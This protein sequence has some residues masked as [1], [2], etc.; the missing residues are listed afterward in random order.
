MSKVRAPYSDLVAGYVTSSNPSDGSFKVKT[1]G[2]EELT[3]K[4]NSA[5]YAEQTRNL[6]DGWTNPPKGYPDMLVPDQYVFA[7]GLWYPESGAQFLEAKHLV[8]PGPGAGEYVFEQPDWWVKQVAQIGDF[9]INGQFGAGEI[10]YKKYRTKLFLDGSRVDESI[11]V[12]Q[13]SSRTVYGFAPTHL[14]AESGNT[15]QETDTISRTVYG[16]AS[17]Y[18]LTGEDRYLEA[19]EKGTKYLQDVMAKREK[20]GIVYWLH[21]VDVVG[22][23]VTEILPSQFGDDY[24]AMPTYEQIYAIA[25][26]TQTY[27]ISGDP[28]ILSDIEKT[29]VLFDEYYKDKGP[30]GGY[31]SHLDP[32]NFSAKSD[33]LGQNKAKKNWNSVGD[34]A[35]AYLINLY[36][37]TGEAKY[38]DFLAYT[39]DTIEAHFP[40]YANSPFVNERFFDDWSHDQGWGWQGNRAVVGHNLK[41][42][43]NLL[44]IQS[45]RPNPKYITF[46]EKIAEIMPKVGMDVQR[47]GWY[48][49]ME[50]A[51]NAG[52]DYHRLVYHD[53]KAWWQ[54]EQGILAYLILNGILKKPEYLKLARESSAFYNAWFLDVENGGVYFNT[55]ADGIPYLL[56][57]ERLKGSHSMG[58]YHSTELCY[59]AQV[60]TNLLITKKPLDMYFKPL[61]G[62]FKNNLLYVTPDILPKGS[63]RIGA[64]TVDGAPYSDYDAEALTVKIPQTGSRVKIHVRID[65]V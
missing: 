26:P 42:A 25:G 6:G 12:K 41:I 11:E 28:S 5:T 54:Q 36:C 21:A 13:P 52:E 64:V 2:G 4:T 50:R 24:G 17:A 33:A 31:Y 62:G 51:K 39:A 1:P 32:A 40:D 60:Y 55:M 59:L 57:N 38:A 58:A 30:Q 34:H 29:I 53:R 43:W 27:R 14:M 19:A 35:P 22:D 7:F 10:D 65:P 44:R 3:V 47:G 45:V 20:D 9:Y 48:D 61:P 18:L 56:G 16:F 46:A 63:I 23:K 49:V 37:A 15:R 8:F